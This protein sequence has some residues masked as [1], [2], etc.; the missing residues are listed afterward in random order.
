MYD[1]KLMVFLKISAVLGYSLTGL[2]VLGTFVTSLSESNLL[3]VSFS[4]AI[5]AFKQVGLIFAFSVFF[6]IA[7]CIIGILE[8]IRM[9]IKIGMSQNKP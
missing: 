9:S 1:V 8:D 5:L 4:E 6:H 2:V 7:D 3:S